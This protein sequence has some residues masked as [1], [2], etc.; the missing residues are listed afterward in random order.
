MKF[1]NFLFKILFGRWN[2]IFCQQ[3][4]AHGSW[5]RQSG[6]W[7]NNRRRGGGEQGVGE[8][9]RENEK[10]ENKEGGEA[11]WVDFDVFCTK[12]ICLNSYH[13]KF[14]VTVWRQNA[15]DEETNFAE[16]F[17]F[18]SFQPSNENVCNCLFFLG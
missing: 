18:P 11:R 16:D 1:F 12:L 14:I 7:R 6:E 15:N 8:S 10:G 9:A 4:V 3:S 13:L 2:I 17:N 5:W